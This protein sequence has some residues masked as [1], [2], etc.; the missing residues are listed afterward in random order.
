M[1][2]MEGQGWWGV[3]AEKNERWGENQDCVLCRLIFKIQFL[4]LELSTS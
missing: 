1:R 4:K 3:K 2:L